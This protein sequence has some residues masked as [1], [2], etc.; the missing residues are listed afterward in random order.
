MSAYHVGLALATNEVEISNASTV[1][2]LSPDTK[3]GLK[4]VGLFAGIGLICAAL[5]SHN[6]WFSMGT[7]G[8]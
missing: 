5:L 7:K 3:S 4:T 6:K 2:A 8:R 1:G